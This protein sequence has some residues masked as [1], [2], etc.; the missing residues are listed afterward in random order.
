MYIK[1]LALITMTEEILFN[2]AHIYFGWNKNLLNMEHIW[3]SCSLPWPPT[4]NLSS[5]GASLPFP[6]FLFT[7]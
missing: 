2:N 5:P 7:R 1:F 3:I 6:Q 4:L